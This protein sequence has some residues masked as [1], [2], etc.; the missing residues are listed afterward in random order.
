[1]R[2]ESQERQ[3]F[4]GRFSESGH[5]Y[6][7]IAQTDT[8][9]ALCRDALRFDTKANIKLKRVY[10]SINDSEDYAL[11]EFT[12]SF[13]FQDRYEQVDDCGF[14][15]EF[16][17]Y[18]KGCCPE[19]AFFPFIRAKGR[20][21]FEIIDTGCIWIGTRFDYPLIYIDNDV[22]NW[23]GCYSPSGRVRRDP[24]RPYPDVIDY[25][26]KLSNKERYPDLNVDLLL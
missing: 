10:Q 22:A 4:H 25:L 9:F 24:F 17:P 8:R 11:T 23:I 12:S 3:K 13:E 7:S 19:G 6:F 16:E 20:R 21:K 5:F 1:M 26:P 2:T 18:D 15:G 14:G